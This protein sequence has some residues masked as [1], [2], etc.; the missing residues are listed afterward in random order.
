MWPGGVKEEKRAFGRAV[1]PAAR[2]D[3]GMR[4][5]MP[6][7]LMFWRG[8]GAGNGKGEMRGSSLRSG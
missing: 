8:K 3:I 2:L 1:A 4:E 5:R 6:F 7:R